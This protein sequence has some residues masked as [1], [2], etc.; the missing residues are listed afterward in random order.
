MAVYAGRFVGNI[1]EKEEVSKVREGESGREEGVEMGNKKS[2][3]KLKNHRLSLSLRKDANKNAENIKI[4]LLGAGESGKSTIFKQMKLLYGQGFTDADRAKMR[5]FLVSNVIEGAVDIFEAANV[6]GTAIESPEAIAAGELLRNLDD[7]R[8]F[9]EEIV[10]ALQVLWKDDDFQQIWSQRSHFQVQDTFG[11]LIERL[12]N[13]PEWGGPEWTPSTEEVLF[14][15]VRTTGIV[16]EQ[17]QVKGIKLRMLDVGGQRN[18]RRKW[19]HSFEGVTSLIFVA[20]MSDY[21]QVLFEDSSKNRLQEAV[22]L[23]GEVLEM[24]W[25]KSSAVMLFLNKTD[26]FEEKYIEKGVPLNASG[27]FPKAPSG[28]PDKEAAYKWFEDLFLQ[29]NKD[30]KRD[31][32]THFTNATDTKTINAVMNAASRHILK[33]NLLGSGLHS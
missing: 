6:V 24:D 12:K 18:E 10:N 11:E 13:Y 22:E 2:A 17:F 29:Q 33:Q 9:T 16:D 26:L 30:P 3:E 28:E 14:A 31:I 27:L 25:F 21:D 19:I 32:Y 15:R 20:S 4:L 8:E 7:R 23:F 5:P 1:F